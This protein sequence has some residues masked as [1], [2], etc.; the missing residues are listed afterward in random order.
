MVTRIQKIFFI[1]TILLGLFVVQ[2]SKTHAQ[3]PTIGDP[4]GQTEIWGFYKSMRDMQA[5]QKTVPDALKPVYDSIINISKNGIKKICKRST[6]IYT[7]GSASLCD[8][9]RAGFV[10]RVVAGKDLCNK[11]RVAGLCNSRGRYKSC[12]PSKYK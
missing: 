10:C 4:K 1:L 8:K 5:L 3:S 6:Y 11:G 7:G 9:I 12:W 2:S